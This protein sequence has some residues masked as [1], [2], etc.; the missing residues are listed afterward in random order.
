MYWKP[1]HIIKVYEALTAIADHRIT[2]T[3][4]TTAKCFSSSGN[5]FYLVSYDPGS[6]SIN[7]ND[8]SAFYTK[9]LSY[10]MI[11]MLMLSNKISYSSE[12]LPALKGIF[13]KK[14]N[15]NFKN[16]YDNLLADL[17]EKLSPQINSE[18]SQI[19]QEVI[20]LKLKSQGKISRPPDAY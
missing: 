18:I 14:L 20:K 10:P 9:T 4:P 6:N 8:N 19:Y 11:A 13:W 12:L 7:S 3:S 16:N 5:K 15:Q 17:S 2:L 1:P